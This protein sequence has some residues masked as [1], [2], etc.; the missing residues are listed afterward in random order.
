[1]IKHDGTWW[2]WWWWWWWRWRWRWRWWSWK[3]S[4]IPSIHPV[5][6]LNSSYWANLQLVP[7][8]L[9]DV[10][11]AEFPS[12]VARIS[13]FFQSNLGYP[14]QDKYVSKYV[15]NLN[16]WATAS[17]LCNLC[18]CIYMCYNILNIILYIYIHLNVYVY[19][20]ICMYA[21]IYIYT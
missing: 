11:S 15:W 7:Q 3:K 10:A 17:N 21:Y 2:W 20:Y 18:M 16:L 12:S 9:L 5:W 14:D 1:M 13:P 6:V 19:I 4:A 8:V